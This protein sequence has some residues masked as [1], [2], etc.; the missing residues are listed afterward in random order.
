[1]EY[2]KEGAEGVKV[3]EWKLEGDRILVLGDLRESGETYFL[4]IIETRAL[5]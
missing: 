2:K 1:M 4:L 3:L 5:P